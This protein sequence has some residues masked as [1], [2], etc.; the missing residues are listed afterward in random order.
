MK[1]QE[2]VPVEQKRNLVVK[3]INFKSFEGKSTDS[4]SYKTMNA[5]RT[6]CPSLN[7]TFYFVK[8]SR[9]NK[10]KQMVWNSKVS[11]FW[12]V[13]TNPNYVLNITIL[14]DDK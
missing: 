4:F 8:R 10:E 5:P 13:N 11:Q 1:E 9:F 12:E 6:L 7:F 14:F 2:E 3:R